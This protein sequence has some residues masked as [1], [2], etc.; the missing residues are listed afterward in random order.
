MNKLKGYLLVLVIM[1]FCMSSVHAFSGSTGVI[2]QN[3]TSV[4]TD[5]SSGYGLAVKVADNMAYVCTAYNK[6]TP[7]G[8]SIS[9]SLNDDW[10]LKTRMG[11][12]AILNAA[13]SKFSITGVTNEYFA[14]EM[15]INQFL[16]EKNGG[17]AD[18][19]LTGVNNLGSAYKSLYTTYLAAANEAYGKDTSFSF[20]VD[21]TNLTFTRSGDN[22]VSNVVTVT[23]N[24]GYD[25][26]TNIGSI[27]KN[28][29][30]FK[31]IVPVS[32]TSMGNTTNVNVTIT[33]GKVSYSVA[34]NYTCGSYQTLTPPITE[35]VE[36]SDKKYA[37]GS[38]TRELSKIRVNKV[39]SKNKKIKNVQFMLQTESQYKNN[40]D[41]TIKVTDG[42]NDLIFD[43]LTAGKYY[44][45]EIRPADGYNEYT[46]IITVTIDDD[47]QAYVNV[48]KLDNNTIKVTNTKTETK[49]SKINAVDGKELPG[50]TLEILNEKKEKM[51]CTILDKDGK[52][53][54]LDECSW[55]SGDTPVTIIGLNKGKYYLKETIAPEGFVL[56]QEMVEFEVTAN[57]T[58]GKVEMK[59]EL[60][61][62]VP[63]TLS[64]KSAML[65][66]IAMFD[67]AL[68][69]GIL[70][71]VKRNRIE[72]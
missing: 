64:T 3:G 52:E 65:V 15:A 56:N 49:I 46:Q 23:S 25:V 69:I 5:S 72:E 26:S 45:K 70:V 50:A 34:R 17:H 67:I 55:V 31:V 53:K 20:S 43:N 16:Y 51:S 60:I 63:N 71:Y 57:G 66:A 62:E 28:G 9:C 27:E 36:I 6:G 40:I 22:Y 13:S 47:G 1:F 35:L 37:S 14:A 21:T 54:V 7:A 42:T 10:D 38:I 41:G 33:S 39:D 24:T 44:L 48:K 29:N 58:T 11:V 61:V 4:V 12:A 19:H 32:S 68:G 2:T 8:H 18:N 59:N 30:S